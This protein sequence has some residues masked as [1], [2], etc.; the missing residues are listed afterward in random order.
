[1]FVEDLIGAIAFCV[2]PIVIFC[3]MSMVWLPFCMY[4]LTFDYINMKFIKKTLFNKK[5]YDLNE[6]DIYIYK[7]TDK[8]ID[9]NASILNIIISYKDE[10][11]CKFNGIAFE[12]ITGFS[13]NH[14]LN[15]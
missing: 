7:E 13:I 8:F 2:F 10:K 3:L 4:K 15:K 5:I 1:M 14:I 12:Q 9:N 11:I 6:I